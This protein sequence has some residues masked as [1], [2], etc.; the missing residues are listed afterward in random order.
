MDLTQDDVIQVLKLLEESEFNEL[1]LEMGD[2]KLVVSKDGGTRVTGRSEP[3]IADNAGPTFLGKTNLAVPEQQP[4]PPIT[5][6]LKEDTFPVE[7]EGVIAIESPMLGTFYTAPKPTDP[8]FVEV[9]TIVTEED[10]VC[11]VEV[12]KLF[13]SI[14]AGVRGRVVK[15][16]AE[17]GDMVEYK[18]PLFLIENIEEDLEKKKKINSSQNPSPAS[19]RST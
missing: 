9:G 15:I 1:R 11:I 12:M 7:Q 13:T 19:K 4:E 14:K 2:L 16:C 3:A 10:T 6:A 17:N 5:Q 8:P 18:Q